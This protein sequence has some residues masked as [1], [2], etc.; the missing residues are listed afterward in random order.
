MANERLGDPCG[1]VFPV[2]RRVASATPLHSALEALLAGPTAAERRFGYGGWFSPDTAG[3]LREVR[4]DGARALVSFDR[5]LAEVIPNASS[6]CGSAGLLAQLDRTTTQFPGVDEAWYSLDGDRAAFYGWLQLGAPDDPGVLPTPGPVRPTPLPTPTGTVAPSPSPVGREV[7][8]GLVGGEW[9]ALPTTDRVIALTFDGGA[10][11]DGAPSIL[12]TL[13]AADVPATF[14]FTG[15]WAVAYPTHA[16]AIG[17][18]YVVG[19]H[20][21]SHPDLTTLD[22]NAV[23]AEVQQAHQVIHQTTGRDP[24]PWFRFPFGAR[25]GR[26]TRLVNALGYGSV[27]WSIDTLGWQG[28]SAGRTVDSVVQR[29]VAGLAPGQIVL[30]HMGSHPTDGSTLDADALPL[31]IERVRAAGYGFVDLDSMLAPLAP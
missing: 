25:D 13:A 29:V 24:R 4:M 19:N 15:T 10:N 26:T 16:S 1:E 7:P 23:R 5:R 8:A 22:D 12:A 2:L 27:R 28:T 31:V 21:R 17:A 6:S 3:L 11:G 14:F 9:T 20:T 30:M 18:R